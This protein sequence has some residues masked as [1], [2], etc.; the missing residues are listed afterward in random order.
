MAQAARK[1][2]RVLLTEGSSTSAREA[3][4]VLGLAGH[5][6]E[7][8]DPDR[9]CLA[10][11]SRFVA[12]FH[13]CPG[14]AEHPA[15]FLA[16]VENLLARGRFDVLLP[17]HEQGFLLARALP[18]IE[19]RAGIA[20]PAFESYRT[21]HGKVGFSRLLDQLGLPQPATNIVQSA[22]QLRAVIRFP[23]VVKTAIGTASRGVW[24]IRDE[25]ALVLALQDLAAHDGFARG[26]LLQDFAAG[27]TE[28]AQAVFCRGKLLGFH[29]FRQIAAGAGGGDARKESV[30]RPDVRRHLET[31]GQRLDWHGALSVDYVLPDPPAMPLYIDGNPRLVEPMSAYLAGLDLVELLL[32]VSLGETPSAAPDSRDGVRTHLALQAVLGCA[33][34]GGRRGGI[35]RQCVQLLTRRNVYAG[36]VEELTPVGLDWISAVPL[37]LTMGLLLISPGLA[38]PL[39]K[40]GWGAHLLSERAV[41][42]IEDG[43]FV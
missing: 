9:H 38:K 26:V 43:G 2:L 7:V 22:A 40:D 33:L 4:T 39:A 14:L 28:K 3:I 41:R 21:A 32:R 30:S 16:F 17:T 8:C 19:A 31:I 10:R 27:C 6:V 18:R 35:F 36:S 15:A 23:C 11:F 34:R 29:A 24:L 5:V 25:A 12:R 37:A 20:L 1:P 13:R 42:L